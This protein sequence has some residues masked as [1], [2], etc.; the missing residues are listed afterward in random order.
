ML[1]AA[2]GVCLIKLSQDDKSAITYSSETK[3]KIAH[4]VIISVGDTVVTDFGAKITC[5]YKAGDE[6]YF[7]EYESGWD[8]AFIDGIKYI[9]ALFKDI[10]GKNEK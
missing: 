8:A 2:P 7:L 5:P 1:T 3:G 4:G 6:V 10:R 9:F